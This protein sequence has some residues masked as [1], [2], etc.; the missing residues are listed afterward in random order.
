MQRV[1]EIRGHKEKVFLIP[2]C[3]KAVISEAAWLLLQFQMVLQ[4]GMS[5]SE[6]GIVGTTVYPHWLQIVSGAALPALFFSS[7][8]VYII[9]SSCL[10]LV[11]RDKMP[12]FTVRQIWYEKAENKT[13]LHGVTGMTYH[14]LTVFCYGSFNLALTVVLTSD[15]GHH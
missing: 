1:A 12:A 7:L 3:S 8:L 11:L 13:G 6:W 10:P 9:R 14:Y 15:I 5:L 4:D 2:P